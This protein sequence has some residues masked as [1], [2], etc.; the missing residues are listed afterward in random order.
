M[1]NH[2]DTLDILEKGELAILRTNVA[3]YTGER[4]TALLTPSYSSPLSASLSLARC[5]LY[6]FCSLS[7][8]LS[9]SL[10]FSLVFVSVCL[11]LLTQDLILCFTLGKLLD[12]VLVVFDYIKD[13]QINENNNQ[14]G[15]DS[16]NN[17]DGA[18]DVEVPPMEPRY[19][20]RSVDD[21]CCLRSCMYVCGV[22]V[23]V[24][25]IEARVCVLSLVVWCLWLS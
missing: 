9:C 6:L 19:C 7:L 17:N 24:C 23:Y 14:A 12:S 22:M 4:A 1:L 8:P 16:S 21:T 11:Y 15:E 10:L 3:Y 2:K 18:L 20:F 5:P 25:Y 13:F